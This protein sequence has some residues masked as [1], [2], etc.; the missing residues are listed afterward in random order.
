MN[1]VRPRILVIEDDEEIRESLRDV[2]ESE[3]YDVTTA[4][5]GREGLARLGAIEEPCVILLDLMMPVMSGGEFLM[6]LQG[7]DHAS[8]PV[9]VVSAWPQEA[10]LLRSRAQ[11][12]LHKPVG[13]DTLLSE[14][15]R[16]CGCAPC[17]GPDGSAPRA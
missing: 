3:N 5:N 4:A 2:L 11:G 13:L 6:A 15:S 14:V 7:T 8:T 9:V 17:G 12:F 16:F 10:S 1:A